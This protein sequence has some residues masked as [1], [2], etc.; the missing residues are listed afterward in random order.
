VSSDGRSGFLSGPNVWVLIPLAGISI[1]IFGV[2]SEG[3]LAF[4]LGAVLLIAAV[5]LA[6]RNVLQLKHQHRLEELEAR[7]QLALVER[8]R[9]VAIDRMLEQEGV[10]DPTRPPRPL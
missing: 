8:E 2:V 5:T 6:T 7:Q 3:P 9:F 10:R 4:F 1:P